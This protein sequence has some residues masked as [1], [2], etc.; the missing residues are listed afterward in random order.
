MYSCRK[1]VTA[2]AA[3]QLVEEG[4]LSLDNKLTKSLPEIMQENIFPLLK[5]FMK[6]FLTND[7]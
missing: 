2:V 6:S 5:H 3:L 4:K 1:V 7:F